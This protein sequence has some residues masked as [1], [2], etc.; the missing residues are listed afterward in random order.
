MHFVLSLQ[1]I[2]FRRR[3]L[4]MTSPST[5]SYWNNGLDDECLRLL[6]RAVG[7]IG[8]NVSRILCSRKGPRSTYSRNSILAFACSLLLGVVA[9]ELL[10]RGILT[11][12]PANAET[13]IPAFAFAFIFI[14]ASEIDIQKRGFDPLFAMLR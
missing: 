1:T 14:V 4:Y 3:L 2:I 7:R 11:F 8:I 5:L 10:V 9:C 6:S 12:A 13:A